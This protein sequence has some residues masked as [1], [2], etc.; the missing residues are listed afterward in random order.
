MKFNI[1]CS[2]TH[3]YNINN[4]PPFTDA[5]SL[6][7]STIQALIASVNAAEFIQKLLNHPA[8]RNSSYKEHESLINSILH[9]YDYQEVRKI[10]KIFATEFFF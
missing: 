9:S 7:T 1:F 5:K 8:F 10:I 4:F 6:L 2:F 3:H